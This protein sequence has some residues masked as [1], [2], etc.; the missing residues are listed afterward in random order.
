MTTLD[1]RPRRLA[2]G[3]EELVGPLRGYAL[4][5][6]KSIRQQRLDEA[7]GGARRG[8]GVRPR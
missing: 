6:L 2:T 8:G 7:T 1:D 3:D 5:E 4:S